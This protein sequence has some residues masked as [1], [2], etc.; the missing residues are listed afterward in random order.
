MCFKY[1]AIAFSNSKCVVSSFVIKLLIVPSVNSSV[2]NV[3][4]NHAANCCAVAASLTV[5]NELFLLWF[6]LLSF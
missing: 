4:P 2:T 6:L 3:D 1:C 5:I